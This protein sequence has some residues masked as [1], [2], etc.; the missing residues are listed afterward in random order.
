VP[1]ASLLLLAVLAGPPLGLAALLLGGVLL[2]IAGRWLGGRGATSPLRA[3]LAWAGAP[4]AL[5]LP[6]W[7][8]QLALLPGPSF[9]GARATGAAALLVALI[10]A[11]HWVLW[12]WAALLAVLGVAEAHRVGPLRGALT[13]LAAAATLVGGAALV[14]GGAALII[15]L[16]G[17]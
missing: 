13:W 2:R 10:Q 5:G 4:L 17:G 12:A 16:R 14:L 8:M 15:Q 9:G 1:P 6:L 3:A 7:V 11:T